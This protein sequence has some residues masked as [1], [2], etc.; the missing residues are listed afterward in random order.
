MREF[1]KGERIKLSAAGRQQFPRGRAALGV[2]AHEPRDP[3][4]IA[5]RWDGAKTSSMYHQNFIEHAA[6]RHHN[7]TRQLIESC[8]VAFG[9]GG[10]VG[11]ASTNHYEKPLRIILLAMAGIAL[12]AWFGQKGFG[13][14]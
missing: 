4:I 12:V 3:E 2:V 1:H 9:A 14:E 10:L 13:V 8:M 7:M 6:Q 5:V 11:I